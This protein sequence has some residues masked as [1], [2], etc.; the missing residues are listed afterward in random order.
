[1][2][3][4]L[5]LCLF[6]GSVSASAA[7]TDSGTPAPS[8]DETAI[9]AAIDSYKTAFD[10]GDAKAVA[11]HWT[12]TGEFVTPGGETLTG[13]DALEKSFTEYFKATPD[14]KIELDSVGIQFIS[15]GV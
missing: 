1:Q 4:L 3:K 12:P 9:R 8:A 14:V 2:L 6:W 7:D 10:K 15:P 5:M 13:H 11:E